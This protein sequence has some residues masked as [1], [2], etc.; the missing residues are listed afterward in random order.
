[1]VR[2]AYDTGQTR[3]LAANILN[4][5]TGMDNDTFRAIVKESALAAKTN[6]TRRT[7]QM[8]ELIEAVERWMGEDGIE[9]KQVNN[10]SRHSKV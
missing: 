5:Q 7:P 10:G 1:M 2:V 9:Q 6:I 4:R 3:S 8:T